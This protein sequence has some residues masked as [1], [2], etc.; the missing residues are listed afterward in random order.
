MIAGMIVVSDGSEVYLA[1]RGRRFCA[2][3]LDGLLMVPFTAC[4]F[5]AMIML[6]PFFL[7]VLFAPVTLVGSL[8]MPELAEFL[9]T[10]L[11][12]GIGV[13]LFLAFAFWFAAFVTQVV[14]WSKGTSFG[15]R[16]L[17]LYV[18]SVKRG[19]RSGFGLMFVREFLC[20]A[21][22]YVFGVFAV[23]V[24]DFLTGASSGSFFYSVIFIAWYAFIFFTER[25]QAVHDIF[26]GTLVVSDSSD[27]TGDVD[28]SPGA[29]RK[30][31]KG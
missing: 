23:V 8:A 18:F 7:S 14:F 9:P 21:L 2:Y 12:R 19:R 15:K 20:K 3:L 22:P 25:R 5:V 28:S 13:V 4:L 31:V 27:D 6:L 16:L 11:P 26:V 24:F 10:S 30:F 1:S 29:P 17:G